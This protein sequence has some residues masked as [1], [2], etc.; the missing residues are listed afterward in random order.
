MYYLIGL[1]L[2][3]T[4]LSH[5]LER[6]CPRVIPEHKP[7]PFHKGWFA[8]FAG[9]VVDGPFLAALIE[10]C[11]LWIVLQFPTWH[12]HRF[13]ARW[14]WALQFAVYFLVNDFGRY[15]LHRWFHISD[16][17]WRFH[18]VHHTATQMGVLTNFR[19][20]VFEALPK[21]G[22]LVLPFHL[23]GVNRWVLI[24]YSAIDLIKGFWHHIN[25]KT[26][27]GNANLLFNSAELHWWHHST[28]RCGQ[29]ANFG[30]VLSIW[31]RLFGTFYWPRGQWPTKIG[32]AGIEAFPED[33]VGR[34]VSGFQDE[35]KFKETIPTSSKIDRMNT[36]LDREGVTTPSA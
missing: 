19:M 13:M 34:F 36:L 15:W 3:C 8:D 4:I 11:A 14:P 2:V 29:M 18:R 17:L 31:D 32:V 30:S 24:T 16:V 5:V 28:E 12:E 6:V 22:L 7:G 21:Y 9:A 33:Y 20:H 26:H 10:I 23:V 27:I 1:F 25:V 35:S